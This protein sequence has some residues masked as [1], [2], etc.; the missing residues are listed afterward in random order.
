M[1]RKIRQTLAIVFFAMVTLLFLDFTGTLHVWFGWMAEIQF[2]P[3][4]LALNI[5][6][7]V[8]LLLLTLLFGRIYCSIICPLGVFQDVVSWISGKR[9]GKKHRFAYSPALTWLRYAVLVLFVIA[10]IAGINSFVALL[11]PYSSY[12]RMASNLFAPLWQWGNNVLAYL[13]E[14]VGSYAFYETEVWIKSLPTFILA[15]ITFVVIGVLAWHNGRTYCNTVCPVGTLLGVVS[16][17]S[18]YRPVIDVEQCKNCRLCAKKCKSA[19]IDLEKHQIDYSR[20]VA[21][22]DCLDACKHGAIHYENRFRQERETNTGNSKEASDSSRRSFLTLAATLT[23]GSVLKAQEK[24]VDG[25][26]AP[27]I[28]K[29]K[30]ERQTPI[31]PPGAGDK[32]HFAQHCTACQLCVSECPN[33]V[34]RPSANLTTFMQPQMSYERGYCR[35]ECMRCAE[36][37]P[38]GA[39]SLN[40]LADKVSTQVGHAVFV[41]EL[42]VMQ[43]D[44][45]SCGNCARHCPTG[46]IQM[47]AENPDDPESPRYP[48]VNVETCIGCGACENLCPSRP[49][50]AIYVEGHERQR[51][52]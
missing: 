40:T 15:L 10:C 49:Y 2:L 7:V 4:L 52:V 26:L 33:G 16:R 27:I 8:F 39:I 32:R 45:V 28:D 9:K 11:A 14:R 30:P 38:T 24:K 19:C 22:M 37:C 31:L 25:G 43:R 23:V 47:V 51:L 18:L 46:S 17:F 20:C 36:V 42:C 1:L 48:V 21:C 13:A 3:A 34:L 41:K 44:G 50:S 29:K 5:G 6:V 12:G 35:P